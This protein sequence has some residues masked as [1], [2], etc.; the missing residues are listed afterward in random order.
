MKIKFTQ[1]VSSLLQLF[2]NDFFFLFRFSHSLT[3]MPNYTYCATRWWESLARWEMFFYYTNILVSKQHY[4][5]ITIILEKI[6]GSAKF[7]IG[8]ALLITE[9]HHHKVFHVSLPGSVTASLCGTEL[10]SFSP[11]FLPLCVGWMDR[12]GEKMWHL[13]EKPKEKTF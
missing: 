2:L 5:F 3:K 13:V 7:V 12:G 9:L 11:P 4:L 10:R 8:T 6:Y 1:D